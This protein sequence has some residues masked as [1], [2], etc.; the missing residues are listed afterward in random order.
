V[1]GGGFKSVKPFQ[2]VKRSHAE[3]PSV[4]FRPSIGYQDRFSL[5]QDY[6]FSFVSAA[7][8]QACLGHTSKREEVNDEYG[9]YGKNC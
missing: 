2:S 6:F 8:G 5:L 9:V 3:Y 4:K 7:A 1:A